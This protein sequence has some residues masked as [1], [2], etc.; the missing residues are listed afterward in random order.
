MIALKL[1]G[2][3]SAVKGEGCNVVERSSRT[4]AAWRSNAST[5]T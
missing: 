5:Q 4:G 1:G 3:A 2:V